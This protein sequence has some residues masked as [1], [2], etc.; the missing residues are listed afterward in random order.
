MTASRRGFI[1][2]AA[3]LA[4]AGCATGLSAPLATPSGD[5]SLL[6]FIDRTPLLDPVAI[7]GPPLRI[8]SFDVAHWGEDSALLR[9]RTVDGAEGFTSCSPNKWVHLEPLFRTIVAPALIGEDAREIEEIEEDFDREWYEYQG[10]PLWISFA[11]AEHAIL[12]LLGR[13]AGRP[14]ARLFADGVQRTDIPFYISSNRRGGDPAQEA[15]VILER[16]RATGCA[17]AKFKIGRRMGQNRDAAPGWTPGIT[18]A[19]RDA[20]GS[21]A[22]L[23]A[24]A[25]GCYDAANALE[26]CA[27]LADH[28]V[29]M[30]EEPCPGEERAMTAQVTARAP[31]D[32]GGGEN[33]FSLPGLRDMI[34]SRMFS[35]C[36][37]DPLYGGGMLRCLRVMKMAHAA[38]LKINPHWPRND[39]EVGPLVH[40]AAVT[41]ALWGLQ[42]YRLRDNPQPYPHTHGYR[43]Q[44]GSIRLPEDPGLGV[45][46]GADAMR[47]AVSLNP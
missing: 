14:V 19:V 6:T 11:H 5:G 33:E 21:E 22:I 24:D 16:V 32:I 30:L 18:R 1:T 26:M 35:V 17:G 41:P 25:N 4:T 2:G 44:N 13:V 34:N 7:A 12:D 36:Q 9:V 39:A 23:Y 37:F 40:L 29:A 20:L 45:T 27:M 47:N 8:A 28:G 46:Y 10:T 3:G 42:E 15:A 38:G 43:L 31:I